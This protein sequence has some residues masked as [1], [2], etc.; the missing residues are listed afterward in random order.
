[1]K[2]ILLIFAGSL[3]AIQSYAQQN[4]HVLLV[5]VDGL[6]PEFYLEKGW[7]TPNLKSLM[8]SGIYANGINSVFPS[9][10]YPAHTTIITGAYPD[11]HGIFYNV[12]IGSSNGH[13]N[14][15]FDLIKTETLWDACKKAG[16]TTG[17]V[18]WPVSVG[19]PI[20]WNF[21]V[22]RADEDE[23]SNQYTITK[24]FVTPSGLI[25]EMT[26][27]NV[28][29]GTEDE[30]NYPQLDKTIGEM[31]SYILG[32][33]QPNL[34]AVHFVGADHYEHAGGRDSKQ[35][36][37]AVALIDK[38]IG[39]LL[40]VLKDN[41]LRES[42]TVIITGDHGFVD[43]E[44]VFSPNVLLAKM[45][46]IDDKGWKA[47]FFTPGGSAFLYVKDKKLLPSILKM[48]D[49]LPPNEKL[50]KVIYRN[51]LNTVG[52]DPS[53]VLA[54]AFNKGVVGKTNI[55]GNLIEEKKGGGNHGY[56]PDFKEIQTGFIITGT[57]ISNHKEITGMGVKDIAPLISEILKLSFKSKDGELFPNIIKK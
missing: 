28:I 38:Q 30:L 2:H 5:S 43:N 32:K 13:W 26:N 8:E 57:G 39:K 24:P 18:M 11:K 50:F 22:R 46:L 27:N 1:M 35:A 25:D 54:L 55:K 3:L 42:T 12:P 19:A 37:I 15:E 9:V 20:N 16:L 36:H 31:S 47:K 4:K 51:Q 17:A 33:H 49:E 48:L 21:P 14:W 40:Q 52:A 29:A 56:Y 7:D 34:M 53:A 6:R 44:Y 10:T 45:G 23:K 41:H